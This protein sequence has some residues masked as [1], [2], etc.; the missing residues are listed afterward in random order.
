[1]RTAGIFCYHIRETD[2]FLPKVSIK[3]ALM[4]NQIH[5]YYQDSPVVEYIQ[6]KGITVQAWYPLGGRGYTSMILGNPML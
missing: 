5:P 2:A 4:Q 1:M 6:N 3:S